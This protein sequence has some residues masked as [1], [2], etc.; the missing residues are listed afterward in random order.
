MSASGP[1]GPLVNFSFLSTR[2]L[3]YKNDLLF[4]VVGSQIIMIA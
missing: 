1:S 2:N 4:V 3:I